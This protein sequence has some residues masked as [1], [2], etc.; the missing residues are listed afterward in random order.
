MLAIFFIYKEISGNVTISFIQVKERKRQ[1]IEIF[2]KHSEIFLFPWWKC[3]LKKSPW[4]NH[5]HEWNRKSLVGG[6]R[7]GE[8]KSIRFF[9]GWRKELRLLGAG[10]V[11]ADGIAE[12]SLHQ[13]CHWR[14]TGVSFVT[15]L[16]RQET[17]PPGAPGSLNTGG[18]SVS[19]CR[20]GGLGTMA[21]GPEQPHH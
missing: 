16:W 14:D 10:S 9:Q 6:A 3:H 13:S 20:T 17:R 8:R 12:R 4:K 18:P 1:T 2:T 5:N 11:W 7:G 19:I 21:R 15:F